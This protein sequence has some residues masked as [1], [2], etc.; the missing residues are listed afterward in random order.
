M[1]KIQ[2][3]KG[4]ADLYT[5][6][7]ALYTYMEDVA[8]RVFGAYGY[9]EIRTPIMEYTELFSRSI[10]TETD[11]VQ[12]EMF[13]MPDRLGR[14]L[15]MR[16]EATAGIMRGYIEHNIAG[17]ESISKFFCYG[18]MFRY[19][20]PQK[21]RM[22]QF[23]QL[24][25]EC[26]GVDDAGADGEM[27]VMLMRFLNALGLEGLSLELNTLG[28]R[29]CRP[30]YKEKLLKFILALDTSQ[31]CEDCQRRMHTNP[32]RVLDC[33]VD[34]C[35]RMTT[36]APVIAQS[37]CEDCHSHFEEVKAILDSEKVP[38]YL[39]DRLVRGLD[40]YM[41][42]TFEVV[43]SSIGSQGSVAGGGRYDGL[44]SQLGGKDVPG[45][46]FA[47]GMERLALCLGDRS[48]VVR[49]TDFFI[50][51][52]EDKGISTAVRLSEVLRDQGLKGEMS[53]AAKSMKSQMRQASKVSARYGLILGETEL[54]EGTVVIRNMESGEQVVIPVAELAPWAESIKTL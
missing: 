25:C 9:D 45:I 46:G 12:K 5:Q 11:V 52:L 37:V 18:P 41:R 48:D 44:I 34:S 33:K 13:T 38:Y 42:T 27:I 20:R 40:Y 22:R 21:G 50:V 4:F 28:C 51:V 14:S 3:V 43:S 2:A 31:L 16:P 1:G 39:N 26:L 24:D 8:R 30:A 6:E 15:T 53:Y 19:E 35:K 49:P 23:H 7:S 54:A 32:L 47:C 29:E 10:G 17:R 36:D